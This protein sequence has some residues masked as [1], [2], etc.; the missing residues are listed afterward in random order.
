MELH[1]F[2]CELKASRSRSSVRKSVGGQTELRTLDFPPADEEL[3]QMLASMNGVVTTVTRR[4][5]DPAASAVTSA[6][7]RL[8]RVPVHVTQRDRAAETRRLR[9]RSVI[10]QPFCSRIRMPRT[11]GPSAAVPRRPTRCSATRLPRV[12][13]PDDHLLPHI[14][15]LREADRLRLDSRFE[16]N[17]VLVHVG[18]ELGTAGFDPRDFHGVR[19]H[20]VRTR[21]AHCIRQLRDVR[22]A[23]ENLESRDTVVIA[24]DDD[25]RRLTEPE[26]C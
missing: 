2:R 5:T 4:G 9:R 13:D 8:G 6:G 23:D 24:F 26:S 16:R 15:T 20:V 1:F 14:A 17:R 18:P 21:R 25:R 12:Q 3:I 22:S 19:G 7:P 10:D 11:S